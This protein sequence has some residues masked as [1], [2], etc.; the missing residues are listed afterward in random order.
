MINFYAT[1]Q[2]KILAAMKP[3]SPLALCSRK[4]EGV[5]GLCGLNRLRNKKVTLHPKTTLLYVWIFIVF[6]RGSGKGD[7]SF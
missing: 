6:T 4:A 2:S 7:V 1:G 3:Q 5:S